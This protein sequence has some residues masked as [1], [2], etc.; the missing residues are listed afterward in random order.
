MQYASGK[1]RIKRRIADEILKWENTHIETD[2]N[3]D[4]RERERERVIPL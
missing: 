1:T 3:G 2:S 4:S